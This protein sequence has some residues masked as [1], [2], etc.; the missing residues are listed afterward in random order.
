MN[1]RIWISYLNYIRREILQLTQWNRVLR[2]CTITK[3]FNLFSLHIDTIWSDTQYI[4][5]RIIIFKIKGLTQRWL[6]FHRKIT[7]SIIYVY[8]LYINLKRIVNK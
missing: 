1:L 2:V 7:E 6:E 4:C 3:G 5:L 8:F